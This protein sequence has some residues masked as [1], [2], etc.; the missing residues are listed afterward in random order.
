M[1]A[2]PVRIL[3][4]CGA[5]PQA[6]APP[7]DAA[8]DA[9]VK[10]WF[11][12]WNALTEAPETHDALASLYAARRAAPDRARRPISAARRRSAA[13]TACA[14]WRR[15]SPPT[16]EK[17]H[18][19]HRHRHRPR[20]D[21]AAPARDH[22]PVGRAGRRRPARRGAHRPRHPE[23]LRHARAPAFFQVDGGKLRRVRDLSGRGRARGS[24]SRAD[25]ATPLAQPPPVIGAASAVPRPGADARPS[26]RLRSAVE[27]LC[28][29]GG[30]A[31]RSRVV[32]LALVAVARRRA[33]A[34]GRRHA[35]ALHA[36]VRARPREGDVPRP[37]RHR[38]ATRRAGLGHDAARRRNRLRRGGDRGRRARPRR[39]PRDTTSPTRDRH[40]DGARPDGSRPGHDPHRLHRHPQRQAARL[41]SEQGQRPEA[42]R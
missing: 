15:A 25:A 6:Q 14:R 16:E 34:A 20:V 5:R 37:R 2:T 13:P 40:A 1:S 31:H 7:A 22:R 29:R 30:H 36:V 32:L 10:L 12:R 35:R 23:A 28:Y 27:R 39:P 41:L 19:A 3:R 8:P 42:T 24:R 9:L 17:P 26:A 11:E 4:I 38:R 21:R 18:L 33:A